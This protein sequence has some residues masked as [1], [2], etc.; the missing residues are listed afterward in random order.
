[1]RRERKG[2]GDSEI[3][4]HLREVNL[5]APTLLHFILNKTKIYIN[6]CNL[7]KLCELP[8]GLNTLGKTNPWMEAVTL[9]NYSKNIKCESNSWGKSFSL[10]ISGLMLHE[11]DF[12]T[13]L[14]C[15]QLIKRMKMVS[16]YSVIS[17]LC[18][19]ILSDRLTV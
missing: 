4:L 2:G 16:V 12:S 17:C 6:Y 11:K 18:L 19:L 8:V 9:I 10:T 3:Y 14:I 5:L 1:M 7:Y 13:L 15:Q